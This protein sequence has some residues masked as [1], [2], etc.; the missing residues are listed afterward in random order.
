M[1]SPALPLAST[2]LASF[3][4]VLATNVV[5]PFLCTRAALRVF[6]SQSPRGGRIVNNGSLAAHVPRPNAGPYTVSK[7]AVAGL[8][9]QTALE[10]RGVGVAVTQLDIGACFFLSFLPHFLDY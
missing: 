8:T 7:H 5:G 2:P 3:T 10:G 1:S 4:T 9:K 6:A